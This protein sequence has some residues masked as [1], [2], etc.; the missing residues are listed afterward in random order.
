MN[1]YKKEDLTFIVD[2]K[3]PGEV[4][5][6]GAGGGGGAGYR[7]VEEQWYE[8]AFGPDRNKMTLNLQWM[9]SNRNNKNAEH[10]VSFKYRMFEELENEFKDLC[11]K[12]GYS[13]T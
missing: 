1:I 10:L 11:Q 5:R 12:Y 8:N 9:D 2:I 3:K 4:R 13:T 7:T 6:G